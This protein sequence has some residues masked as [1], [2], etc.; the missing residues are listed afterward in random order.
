MLRAEGEV[1]AWERC[2]KPGRRGSRPGEHALPKAQGTGI[3]EGPRT[4][5]I[6][7]RREGEAPGKFHRLGAK[8]RDHGEEGI[9]RALGERIQARLPQHGG[10]VRLETGG[11]IG[12][13]FRKKCRVAVARKQA[14]ERAPWRAPPEGTRRGARPPRMR[15]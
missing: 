2:A 15:R 8:G 11:H 12:A 6:P 4:E 10:H 14:I 3:G 7:Q 5:R 13:C 9:R 1:S